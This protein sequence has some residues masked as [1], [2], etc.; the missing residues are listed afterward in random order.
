MHKTS[1]EIIRSYPYPAKMSYDALCIPQGWL[2]VMVIANGD[3]WDV[4]N[5]H[6]LRKS[7]QH[8]YSLS[9]CDPEKHVVQSI[10]S[11]KRLFEKE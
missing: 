11:L 2:E 3:G 1:D 4:W 10:Q 7:W 5:M 6:P 8:V 9:S